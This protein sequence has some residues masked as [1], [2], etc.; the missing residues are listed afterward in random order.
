[1]AKI[2][3][4]VIVGEASGSL[5]STVFS[6]SR[7]GS[8]VRLRAVPTRVTTPAAEQA[9]AR[10][11]GAS[12]LWGQLTNSERLAWTTWSQTNPFTDRLGDKR[13]LSGQAAVTRLNVNIVNC[14]GTPI[15]EPPATSAP[16]GV[17]SVTATYDIGAGN[18][19]LA[20]T[21]TPLGTNDH[22]YVWAAVVN[23]PG[24]TYV[25]NLFKLV[26]VGAAATASPVSTIQAD[27]EARFGPLA[28]G[29]QVFYQLQVVDGTTGLVSGKFPTSGTVVST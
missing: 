23:S 20:F 19:S 21:P 4:G 22:L 17:L 28:V 26:R 7:Y 10:L 9:K 6:H 1:M 5:G 13:I 29:Q 16:G 8:Y 25:Q 3:L 2:R 14:G 12:K 27:I 18:F 11:S 24:V 15:T